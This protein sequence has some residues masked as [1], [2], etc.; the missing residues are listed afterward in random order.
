MDHFFRPGSRVISSTAC[1]LA[2]NRVWLMGQPGRFQ[3]MM[4]VELMNEGPETIL[5]DSRKAL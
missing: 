1:A 4:Q 2:A 3:A 5:L